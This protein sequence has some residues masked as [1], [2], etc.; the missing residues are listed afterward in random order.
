M[1]RWLG[2]ATAVLCTAVL[3]G[4]ATDV[5]DGSS[6][7]TS[8]EPTYSDFDPCEDLSPEFAVK[9][10]LEKL[11]GRVSANA[12]GNRPG[13]VCTYLKPSPGYRLFIA[14]TAADLGYPGTLD[15]ERYDPLQIGGKEAEISVPQIGAEG[16]YECRLVLAR[17][18]RPSR[19]DELTRYRRGDGYEG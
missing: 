12:V 8:Q 15:Q 2:L 5:R 13:R 11:S 3:S 6:A 18:P 16:A 14:A 1:S 9:H 17:L 10:G 19:C 4:C 7:T